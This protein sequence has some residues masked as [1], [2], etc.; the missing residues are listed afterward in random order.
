MDF[1]IYVEND[2]VRVKF[3][4]AATLGKLSKDGHSAAGDY[5]DRVIRI[6]RGEYQRTQRH[7]LLHELGHHL[8]ARQELKPRTASEEDICDLL[9]WLPLILTDERNG[10]LRAFLGLTLA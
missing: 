8:V 3:V 4:A 10:D 9:T 2:R 1:T 7:I 5:A 6:F